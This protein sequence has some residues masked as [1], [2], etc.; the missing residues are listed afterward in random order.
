MDQVESIKFLGVNISADVS[1]TTNTT[2]LVRKAQQ[3][4]LS[5]SAREGEPEDQPA[6]D[7][8]PASHQE[9][10]DPRCVSVA[11][12]L[13]TSRQKETAEGD[14]DCTEDHWL[15]PPISVHHLQLPVPRKS[16]EHYN[17]QYTP[18]FPSLQSAAFSQALQGHIS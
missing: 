14:Q 18:E 5:E 11:L 13:H 6:E 10:A 8:L 9:P 3:R 7:L 15:S 16:N 17:R 2:A 4:V 12:K 1:W